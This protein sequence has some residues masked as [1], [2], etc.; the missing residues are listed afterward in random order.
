VGVLAARTPYVAFA[1]DDS[2][3]GDGSLARAADILDANP[4]VALVTA[5]VLVG[6]QERLDPACLPMID[7][8]LPS[9]RGFPGRRVLGFLACAAVVRRSAFLEV[10]G[11]ERRLLVGG[12]DEL[13]AIDLA[14][15]GWALAYCHSLEV[16][17]H[18]APGPVRA[19]RPIIEARNRLWT[20]W[21][22]RST[23]VAVRETARLCRRAFSHSASRKALWLALLGL[24]WALLNRRSVSRRV[25][26]DL[27]LLD[28]MQ[29]GR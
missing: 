23:R 7:S 5:R 22:R 28:L 27:A 8:P 18:P 2:W 10:G 16:H 26:A 24:P 4:D 17:H 14:A 3:W 20:I 6:E 25:E 9:R 15:N 12:E 29:S 13:L 1:D 19:S 21:L 11:F